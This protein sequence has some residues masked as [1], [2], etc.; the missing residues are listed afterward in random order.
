MKDCYLP[1]LHRLRERSELLRNLRMFFDQR[2]FLEVQPPCLTTDCVIDPYIDPLRVDTR[3]FQLGPCNGK[4]FYYLQTS[5]EAAM[6][7]MLAAG[8]PSIYSLG[9]VF[10]AGEQGEQ[11]DLEFTM[12]E[13][14]ELGSDVEQGIEILGALACDVLKKDHFEVHSYR[15][16]FWDHCGFDPID[17]PISTLTECAEA[18]DSSLA[19]LIA[20]DRDGVLDLILSH[21][22]QPKLGHDSPVIV[23][24]YP[25]SQAALAKASTQDK[26]CAARFELFI[27]GIELAN[28]YDELRDP[29]VL[30]ERFRNCNEKRKK[31]GRRPLPVDVPLLEAMRSGFPQC[32]GVALGVDRLLAVQLGE[33]T[34]SNVMPFTILNV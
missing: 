20:D 32:A 25:L 14:Y 22:I 4:E 30:L 34:I 31:S 16:L 7:R 1:N 21:L 29:D 10:R 19:M 18:I 8:A 23:R 6:K 12:L 5:P 27:A 2:G 17:A 3:E 28:G 15:Q 13:W 26:Q 9:P 24:D 33:K 11:H